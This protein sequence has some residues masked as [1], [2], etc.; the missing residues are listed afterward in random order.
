MWG[1]PFCFPQPTWISRET[2]FN[3]ALCMFLFLKILSWL[4]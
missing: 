4:I 3:H 2:Y 1:C